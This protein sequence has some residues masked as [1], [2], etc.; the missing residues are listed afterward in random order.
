[1]VAKYLGKP[2]TLKNVIAGL[3]HHKFSEGEV[4]MEEQRIV[5]LTFSRSNFQRNNIYSYLM[6]R[7]CDLPVDVLTQA[8]KMMTVGMMRP[9]IVF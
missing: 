3:G 4:V 5:M 9:D 1:M 6:E 7:Y 8:M 2:M